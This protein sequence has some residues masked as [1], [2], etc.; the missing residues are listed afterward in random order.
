MNGNPSGSPRTDLLLMVLGMGEFEKNNETRNSW[1]GCVLCTKKFR[2]DDEVVFC[3]PQK[4]TLG[5]VD[6][7]FDI[8]TE[9]GK[10]CLPCLIKLGEALPGKA[11]QDVLAYAKSRY[12]KDKPK[13]YVPEVLADPDGSPK[14]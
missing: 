5:G 14:A 1:E 7:P 6:L 11:L 8:R 13:V 12:E 10:V 2:S 3:F 9:T 4:L